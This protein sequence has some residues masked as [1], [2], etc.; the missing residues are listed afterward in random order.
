MRLGI[1]Q[2]YFFPYIGY[3][4]LIN[5][6]DNYIIYDDV[7]F[8]KRGWINRNDVL[9][10]GERQ[11]FTLRLNNASQNRLINETEV[12]A[13]NIG[14][15]KLLKL[16]K[17]NYARAPFFADAYGVI[18]KI[19]NQPEKNLAGYLE[20][21]IRHICRY[22]GIKTNI[23]VASRLDKNNQ[24]RGQAMIIEI[25]KVMGA[26]EY[27]NASGG[28][29]LY[30]YNDFAA[31]GIVLKFLNPGE[32][33]YKQFRNDFVPNLSIIDVMMFNEPGKIKDMLNDYSLS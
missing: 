20:I 15:Q 26:D 10:R 21:Q 6:V 24:L 29:S 11:R 22:L 33:K 5:A 9:S 14:K 17:N 4:Q 3:W 8:I 7:N 30:S 12:L 25:C 23:M 27:I 1:M 2:P 16:I 19:V 13:D 18:E 32:I 28:R 31:Q